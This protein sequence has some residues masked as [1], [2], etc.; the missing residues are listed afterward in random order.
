[1]SDEH[2]VCR[3]CGAYVENQAKH[4]RWH[5]EIDRRIKTVQDRWDELDREVRLLR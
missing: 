5:E 3:D 2:E 1:M 4:R